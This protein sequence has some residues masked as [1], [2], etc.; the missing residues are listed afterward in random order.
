MQV[1]ISH[2][3]ADR[4]LVEKL[5]EELRK[6]GVQVWSPYDSLMPGDNWAL[7]TGKALATSDLIVVLFTRHAAESPTVGQE[8][9]YAMTSGNYQGRVVPVLL[10][11][12]TFQAGHD[13]PWVLLRMDPVYVQT[14][15]DFGPVVKRV[16]KLSETGCNATA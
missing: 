7:E 2:A 14:P 12:V 15:P 1:F 10:D 8:V 6:A 13:V 9:Q 5:T 3:W 11:Y 16:Q 4:D